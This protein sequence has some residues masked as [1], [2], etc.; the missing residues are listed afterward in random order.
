[1]D[2][3]S[4]E[5]DEFLK[6]FYIP[7]YIFLPELPTRHPSFVPSCPV[8]VFI[9]TKSGG[10]LGSALLATYCNL[11]N[12][13][14]VF[15]LKEEAPDKVLHKLYGNLEKLKSN[16]DHLAAEILNRLRLIVAGGDGT[17]SWLLGVVCDLR[18]ARPP[19]IITV[20]L[21]TGNNIPFSFGWGMRNPGIDCQSVKSFLEQV[22]K[23]REMKIDS[24]HIIMRMRVPKEG[25]CDPILPL[26]LPHAMHAFQRVSESDSLTMERHQTFRGGF[27]NYFSIG[28]DAQV[29]YAFHHKRKKHPEKFKNQLANQ[30][31]YLKL[32][33]TQG[34]FCTSL[35]Q[36]TSRNI[37]CLAKVKIMKKTGH[38][39]KLHIPNSIRSIV[40]LN[41]PSFSGGLNP[42]GTPDKKKQ[43]DVGFS[44]CKV[45]YIDFSIG[46]RMFGTFLFS[47]KLSY[48]T[49]GFDSTIC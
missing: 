4:P 19:P 24:W 13:L 43:R 8:V 38:W 15:N 42:W 40:C 16:G 10:Q 9:N 22:M 18:L 11:L 5:K 23:A 41:L 6:E 1:M 21:G 49:A 7:S 17:A 37:A 30:R 28:M 12:K 48:P 29:S 36:P 35:F 47:S 14:Q 32:G 25:S 20:P 44:S 26:E 3:F 27:W 2:N 33:C 46:E 31:T 45:L 34:W 39:E